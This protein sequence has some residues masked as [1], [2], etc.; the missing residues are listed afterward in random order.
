ME[1][2]RRQNLLFTVFAAA[3]IV[4]ILWVFL[5]KTPVEQDPAA[6]KKPVT[7]R[8]DTS[9]ATL[10]N[11]EFRQKK[12]AAGRNQLPQ[13]ALERNQSLPKSFAGRTKVRIH[14]LITRFSSLPDFNSI[15]SVNDR[16]AAF[17]DYL[18]PIVDYHNQN[19]LRERRELERISRSIL[20]GEELPRRDVHWLEKLA[21]RY[22]VEWDQDNLARVV[23]GLARRVDIIP[24][25]LAIVQ[26]AKESSWGRSRYAKEAN[27][28]FGQWCFEEG[29]GL[30]PGERSQGA[31]HEVQS[32]SSVFDATRSYIHN[33]NTH[34]SYRNLRQ[35]RQMLR[36]RNKP[37]T[38]AALAEGLL[39][40]SERRQAY[41]EEVKSM[42]QQYRLFQNRRTG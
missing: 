33:L 15:G 38:G 36:L 42:I 35:I 4:A 31:T 17:I 28:L 12:S 2:D 8:F 21:D 37:I 32:F 14:P 3:I 34:P 23:L 7:G 40:Y 25:S 5:E 41:I 11:S 13:G 20:A 22:D 1:Q 26:A 39:F 27:N 16:K 10:K 6:K 18:T 24:I 30:V 29:C 19:I 9:T